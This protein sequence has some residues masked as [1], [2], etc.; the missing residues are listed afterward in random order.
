MLNKIRSTYR[1]LPALFVLIT[2][3]ISGCDFGEIKSQ[4]TTGDLRVTA[5]ETLKKVMLE[6]EAEFER[7][8]KE[9]NVELTFLPS[10]YVTAELINGEVSLI[11]T[12]GGF[13]AE[14]EKAIKDHNIEVQTHEFAVDGVAFIVNPNNPITR[15]TSED[16]KKIFTGEYTRWDQI[17]SQDAE[18]NLQVKSK[19]TGANANIKLFIQRPNS[20]FYS[21]VKDTVLNGADYSKKSDICSTSVQ[22]LDAIRNNEN[23]IGISNLGWMGTG[24]QDILD[25]TVRPLRISRIYPNGFQDDFKQFHQ[26]LVFNSEYPYRRVV[27]VYTTDKGIKLAAGFITFLLNKDGQKVVL[28]EGMVPVTQPVRT[29]QIN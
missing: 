5:D 29:L 8:N 28:K 21:Y 13:T 16:L 26:G 6:E 7:L 4:A 23:A 27:Y 3:S 20:D 9:A 19:M 1:L 22:M 18:Q 11:V 10:R 12:S 17:V 14:E 15:V 24:N 2:L 25:S